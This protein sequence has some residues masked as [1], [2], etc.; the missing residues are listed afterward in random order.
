MDFKH[1]ATWH[2]F[3]PSKIDDENPIRDLKTKFKK[4]YVATWHFVMRYNI[5]PNNGSSCKLYMNG[6]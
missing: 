4:Y 3:T 1:Y 6:Q 2:D 5:V